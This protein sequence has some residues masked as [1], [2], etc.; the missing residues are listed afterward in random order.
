MSMR[1]KKEK[2]TEPS[3]KS[4]C[5]FVIKNK[6]S[7]VMIKSTATTAVA[8]ARIPSMLLALFLPKKVSAPPAIEPESPSCEPD[9]K[10]TIA[11]NITAST[12][13]TIVKINSNTLTPPNKSK[14][15]FDIIPQFFSFGK[16]Y[17]EN[18]NFFIRRFFTFFS[19][20]IAYNIYRGEHMKAIVYAD[21]LF[22]VNFIINMILLRVT[23]AFSKSSSSW[24][25]LC[26]ASALGSVY[27]V[28]MFFPSA[29]MLYIFPAKLAVSLI[30]LVITDPHSGII[31][32]IK[33]CAVFYLAS[34]CFAGVMLAL[35][36]FTDFADGTA[37]MVSNGIF[38]FDIS[39]T[40]LI[41][42][43]C[44]VYIILKLASA[45][46]ARNKVLGIKKLKITLGE[47]ECEMCA[48]SDTGNLLTDPISRSPVIIAD[49]KSVM[50]LFPDGLPDAE[51]GCARG[52]RL[53]VI[54]YSSV[55]AKD[56]LLTGFVPDR[57]ELDGKSTA[58]VVI[59]ICDNAL[60]ENDEYNALFNPNIL[61]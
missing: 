57:I 3:A 42:S 20:R 8:L 29:H 36:Y 49:K 9:W 7:D 13:C 26:V 6:T 16:R 48:M 51:E 45:V 44:V 23:C 11:I 28:C 22:L 14:C 34:F 53:R 52:A 33:S 58:D 47:R 30:M 50:P 35:I 10:R 40:T 61:T 31:K 38:Y 19:A 43:S 1:R 12:T 60:C 55:G 17:F 4:F 56:G 46:F 54:P 37:P 27:A 21:M 5:Y 59:A 24:L 2:Q 18:I 41:A 32:L 15:A 25:R 39:L